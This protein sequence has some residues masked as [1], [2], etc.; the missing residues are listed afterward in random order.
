MQYNNS[1]TISILSVIVHIVLGRVHTVHFFVKLF[2]GSHE[3]T[4]LML[5]FLHKLGLG[6]VG[7]ICVCVSL[8]VW[9]CVEGQNQLDPKQDNIFLLLSSV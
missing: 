4:Q 1:M 8:S 2:F 5:F 9:L 3:V 7:Q 6:Q